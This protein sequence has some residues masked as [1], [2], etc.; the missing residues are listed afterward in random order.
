M[1]RTPRTLLRAARATDLAD[2]HVV[3]SDAE[4]T[5][6]WSTPPHAS[7]DV[8]R[9]W[10]A[11]MMASPP[12]HPDYVIEVEGRVVGK[13]GFYRLPEI[14]FILR[15]ELWGRGLMLEAASAVLAHV[16]EHLDLDELRGDADPRNEASIR[17]LERLGFVEVRRAERTHFI[18]GEWVD[19]VYFV[20]R[21]PR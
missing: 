10:L 17:L 6:Y 8:T 16:D 5:R 2:L 11:D 12:G 13:V 20:R 15:R 14:G 19:S 3:L 7:L 4:A 9:A 18:G 21:R 1:I